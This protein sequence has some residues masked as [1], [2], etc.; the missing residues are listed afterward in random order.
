[1]SETGEEG[2]PRARALRR[3]RR[4]NVVGGRTHKH[5]VWVSAEEELALLG[6]ANVA[7]VSVPRLLVE[8]ALADR[9][10][11]AGLGAGRMAALT[12]LFALTRLVAAMSRNVNQLAK[13]ANATGEL[14]AE[15][16]ATLAAIRRTVGR[17][18]DLAETVAG[19]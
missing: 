11:D 17:L 1:M 4:A 2:K 5:E 12:D 14:P 9:S 7:G 18:D 15:T 16:E 10:E 3:R 6:R 8:S 13:V 19:R